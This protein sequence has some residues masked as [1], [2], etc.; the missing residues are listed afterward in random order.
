M[1]SNTVGSERAFWLKALSR[2]ENQA[3]ACGAAIYPL[4]KFA[5]TFHTFGANL[6]SNWFPDVAMVDAVYLLILAALYLAT[7][8]LI[9]AIE[10]LGEPK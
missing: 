4:R 9:R 5:Q 7:H 10:R 6:T 8:G 1:P 3:L 2:L